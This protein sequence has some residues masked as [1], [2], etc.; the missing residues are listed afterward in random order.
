MKE[1]AVSIQNWYIIELSFGASVIDDS[2]MMSTHIQ[3]PHMEV[4][5]STH[6][7]AHVSI[8]HTSFSAFQPFSRSM[9]GH[10]IICL[11][12]F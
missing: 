8:L 3:Y 11:R 4:H 5:L 1:G 10:E 12:D 2:Y 6:K 7:I 9:N